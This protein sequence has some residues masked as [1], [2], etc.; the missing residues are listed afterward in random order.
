MTEV[1]I[2][3]YCVDVFKW[4]DCQLIIKI[5]RNSSHSFLSEK[6]LNYFLKFQL[7]LNFG[8]YIFTYRV[9]FYSS[10]C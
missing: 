8:T 1:L 9:I 10:G 6:D 3:F 5:I 4:I 2:F 7:K